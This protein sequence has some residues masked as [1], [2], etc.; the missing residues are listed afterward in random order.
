MK[1]EYLAILLFVK[2][3]YNY[4]DPD[5]FITYICEKTDK[6]YLIKYLREK[7]DHIYDIH[8]SHAVMN[9]FFCDL[10]A[11]LREALVDYALNVYAPHGMRTKYEEYKSL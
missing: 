7:F 11:D 1:K 8:G 9:Y 10:D 4:S 3:G 5:E 2:F 6:K